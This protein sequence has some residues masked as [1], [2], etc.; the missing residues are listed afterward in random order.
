VSG[1]VIVDNFANISGF[2]AVHQFVRIGKYAMVGGMSRIVQDVIQFGIDEDNPA[3]LRGL[4]VIRLKRKDFE[5]KKLAI[6][7][8]II[9][10]FMK[11]KYTVKE[12]ISMLDKYEC[13]PEIEYLKMFLSD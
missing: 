1:H 5:T 8:N 3:R 7:R 11:R 10:L 12:I 4:N 13:F 2:V 6:L 9:K